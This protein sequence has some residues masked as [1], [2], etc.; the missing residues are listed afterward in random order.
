MVKTSRKTS[1]DP[2]QETLR[3]MKDDWNKRVSEFIDNVKH[4]KKL[5]NGYPNKFH[6]DKSK[7]T[8]PIPADPNTIIMTLA[9][10]FAD[11]AESSKKII[12]V[13]NDY[14]LN[15]RKKQV[16]QFP[17]PIS[18]SKDKVELKPEDK[19]NQIAS[20]DLAEE[21]F[22]EASNPVTR[23][24]TRLMNPSIGFSSKSRVRRMRIAAL[25][26]S[27]RTFK[28]LEKL[29]VEVVKSSTNSIKVSNDILRTAWNN[30]SL[31]YREFL[32]YKNSQLDPSERVNT[33]TNSNPEY[34]TDTND[35]SP[36]TEDDV[37]MKGVSDQSK[38]VRE[39]AATLA[40]SKIKDFKYFLENLPNFFKNKEYSVRLARLSNFIEKYS[41]HYANPK[42]T[43]ESKLN[44]ANVF[45]NHYNDLL[46]IIN[47]KNSLKAKSFSELINFNPGA[48]SK[49][50]SKK[51]T[52]SEKNLEI[53][54]E[55][56]QE[57]NV[58]ASISEISINKTS[59]DFLRK[60]L[61]KTHHQLKFYDESSSYRLDIYKK[62]D[63][64]RDVLDK[65]MDS[66]EKGYLVEELESYM[67]EVN[68]KMLEIRS[69]MRAL[70]FAFT[71][72]HNNM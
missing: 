48:E 16:K 26:A 51:K 24:F 46:S 25:N 2:F 43:I 32:S 13:Q 17:N 65:I 50:E 45:M 29:Q 28:D 63:E 61:G 60:W 58:E 39:T 42:A 23:F 4:Y 9:N 11:L 31:V 14:S 40:P 57:E 49:Q 19:L 62:A 55:E 1:S 20:L 34:D 5:S 8:D 35:Y 3:R 22:S 64:A 70:N 15:R 7:I 72:S 37:F 52:P 69:I 56:S 44:N 27:A 30:W 71:K 33:N 38:Q 21:L 68:K 47:A 12:D 10:D 67:V 66:L 53:P 18:I 41:L 59:Q 54:P 6:G 36:Q